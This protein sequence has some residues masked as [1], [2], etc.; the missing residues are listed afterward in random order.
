[1]GD[2]AHKGFGDSV[3]T[4]M[5][6]QCLLLQFPCSLQWLLEANG[7]RAELRAALNESIT[8]MVSRYRGKIYAW[9]AVMEPFG[10][11]HWRQPVW[12][13]NL[14]YSAFGPSYVDMV[15]E[16]AQAADPHAKLC[17]LDYQISWGMYAG[18]V[19]D[20]SKADMV[21][22]LVAAMKRNRTSSLSRHLACIC[23]ETHLEPTVPA[24]RTGYDWLRRN[25]DRYHSI[26]VEVHLNAVTISVNGFDRAWNQSQKFAA[27]ATWYRILIQA[28]VDSPACVDFE[29]Y[30]LTDKYDMG[31]TPIY[32]L[33][34]DTNF[35]P[36]P[37]FWAMVD[38]LENRTRVN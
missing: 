24:N 8:T 26:G 19:W 3:H 10:D 33:P 2:D 28:C 38:V 16:I 9:H 6:Y 15:F 7:T 32:S 22:G 21:Y 18:G 4:C 25:F 30:G 11:P 1:M 29:P 36:K 5:F 37:A 14:L 20:H 12:K 17:L 35:Q 34:F 13:E 27:Q 23:M 31:E